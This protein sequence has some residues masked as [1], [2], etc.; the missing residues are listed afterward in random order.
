MTEQYCPRVTASITNARGTKLLERCLKALIKTD[1][2]NLEIIVVDC[3]T[4][5]IDRWV[6]HRFS[7]VKV[8]H[9]DND[10]GPSAS[11]NIGAAEA[12]S[13]SKYIALL[14]NDTLVE[15]NWLKESMKLLEKDEKIGIAQPKILLIGSEK[16]L[17]HVGLALDAL[18]T[19]SSLFNE[20]EERFDEA[21]DIFAASSATCIIRRD[22]FESVAGFDEDYFIYDDDTDFCWRTL[23]LGY[24]IVFAP[25]ARTHHKGQVTKS[26]TTKRL[27]H[28]TKNRVCTALKNYELGNLWPRS[29]LFYVLSSLTAFSLVLLLEPELA[30]AVIKGLASPISDFKTIW[31]KRLIVQNSRKVSDK[32]IFK[33]KLLRKDIYPTLLD[34]KRKAS[35]LLR[36]D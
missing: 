16:R 22:V 12:D 31:R 14:D 6:H 11:H 30:F 23:L 26:L 27:Y 25:S 19:W 29:V 33:Q 2:P 10:I 7:S 21:F 3:Q 5:Q 13:R 20:N 28:S 17:D 24:R 9:F 34:V 18:G 32:E 8:I 36:K 1:Y 15:P 35:A 4:P